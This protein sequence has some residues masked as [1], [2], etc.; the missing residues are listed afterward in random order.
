MPLK[1]VTKTDILSVVMVAMVTMIMP[2]SSLKYSLGGQHCDQVEKNS[3]FTRIGLFYGIQCDQI[4][5]LNYAKQ[6]NKLC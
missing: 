6:S 1:G 2:K 4:I 3:R 5:K